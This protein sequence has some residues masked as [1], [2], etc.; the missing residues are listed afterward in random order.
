MIFLSGIDSYCQTPLRLNFE[1]STGLVEFFT[2]KRV[3]HTRF[4]GEHAFHIE[5]FLLC[6]DAEGN[7]T[8]IIHK[9]QRKISERS[10]DIFSRDYSALDIRTALNIDD[11]SELSVQESVSLGNLISAGVFSVS[12][13]NFMVRSVASLGKRESQIIC[14]FNREG[15]ILYWKEG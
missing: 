7:I 5:R 4:A 3:D 12:S 6:N 8:M 13:S 1:T 11:F 10:A 15:E 2:D 9:I 14:K